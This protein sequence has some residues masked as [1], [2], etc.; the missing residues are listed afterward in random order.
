MT[1]KIIKYQ[2]GPRPAVHNRLLCIDLAAVEAQTYQQMHGISDIYKSNLI[3]T[4]TTMNGNLKTQ[5]ITALQ[6]VIDRLQ[7]DDRSI[8]SQ[9][10]DLK[11]A[12]TGHCYIQK[13]Y[14][15]QRKIL[16]II[17]SDIE[18]EEAAALARKEEDQ[19]L[20]AQRQIVDKFYAPTNY[21]DELMPDTSN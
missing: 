2:K 7:N 20:A 18:D 1:S 4:E 19:R 8:A 17:Q 10:E 6:F 11:N 21:E 14:D 5:Y 3:T 12:L 15:Q 16:E 13:Q 9:I